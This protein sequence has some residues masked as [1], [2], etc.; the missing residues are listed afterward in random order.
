MRF[1][2]IAAAAGWITRRGS[3]FVIGFVVRAPRSNLLFSPDGFEPF[4]RKGV[5]EIDSSC[6]AIIID[7]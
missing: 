5:S 7:R 6:F 3:T 2:V 4:A 1:S